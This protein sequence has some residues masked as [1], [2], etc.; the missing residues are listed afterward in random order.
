[1]NSEP[2]RIS[3][4]F[5]EIAEVLQLKWVGGQAGADKEVVLANF[6]FASK[7]AGHLNFSHPNRIQ[8]IGKKEMQV[9]Q[10]LS[11]FKNQREL[12]R[13]L[14]FRPLAIILAEGL[15]A[16]DFLVTL[17]NTY[18]VPLWTTPLADAHVIDWIRA[19]LYWRLSKIECLHGVFLDV[20]GVGVL[21]MGESSIGKSEL[22]LE[23]ITRG[24][25]LIADDS[26]DLYLIGP[27]TV[28]GKSP[29]LLRHYLEVRGLGILNIQTI[30]GES[31]VRPSM[32]LKLIIELY[33]LDP[34]TE[35]RLPTDE[36]KQ[37]VLDVPIRKIRL[38]IAI[39]R[40][41]A[42]LVEASV[43]KFILETRGIRSTA[44]FIARQKKLI[45]GKLERHQMV[46]DPDSN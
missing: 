26:V 22:A 43:R 41:L 10:S 37:M 32:R 23:L 14:V 3:E 4:L 34:L 39:G 7:I 27:G 2:T 45:E 44:E 17:A 6:E 42:V 5:D 28:Y 31:A 20:F 24:H 46:I 9:L 21:L 30:F 16:N 36:E 15:P 33:P 13:L 35:D 18:D 29:D 25:K 11:G 40:N 19:R 8:V 1:M 12:E 38:P